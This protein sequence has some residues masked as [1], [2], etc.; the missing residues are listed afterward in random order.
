MIFTAVET[1]LILIPTIIHIDS[2][3]KLEVS[4]SSG[5]PNFKEHHTRKK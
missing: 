3:C 4:K 2:L 1:L 5:Y